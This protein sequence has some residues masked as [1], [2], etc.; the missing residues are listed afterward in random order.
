MHLEAKTSNELLQII[1]L[2][3]VVHEYTAHHSSIHNMPNFKWGENKEDALEKNEKVSCM[4]NDD[5]A[6][7]FFDL[8]KI[9]RRFW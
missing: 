9:Y 2:I 8:T 4:L 1:K 5:D 7:S 3:R 6:S